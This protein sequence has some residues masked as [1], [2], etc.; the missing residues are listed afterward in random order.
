LIDKT[1]IQ[2][3]TLPNPEP[4][5]QNLKSKRLALFGREYQNKLIER[6]VEVS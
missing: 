3:K 5:I 4:K 1:Y 2:D 6:N